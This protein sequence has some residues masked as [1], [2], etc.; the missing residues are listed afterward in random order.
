MKERFRPIPLLSPV[1]LPTPHALA[2]QMIIQLGVKPAWFDAFST[3][4]NIVDSHAPRTPS[5]GDFRG[6]MMDSPRFGDTVVPE[7]LLKVLEP[8]RKEGCLLDDDKVRLYSKVVQKDSSLRLAIAAAIFG[9]SMETLF[10]LQLPRALNFLMI[11][12]ANKAPQNVPTSAQTPEIDEASML[13]RI[14]SKG[15]SVPGSGKKIVG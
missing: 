12:K 1:L 14:S 15:K 3:A 7:M 4:M 11:K 2:L 10:W 5:A 13:S 8:Y 9:D 6:Y